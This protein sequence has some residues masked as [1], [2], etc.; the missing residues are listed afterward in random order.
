MRVW[1]LPILL[2][3]ILGVACAGPPE[4]A[5]EPDQKAVSIIQLIAD[6]KQLD[7]SNILVGGYLEIRDEYEHSL[8]LDENAQRTGMMGNSIAI[9]LGAFRPA[10]KKRAEELDR[11]Y[12]IL[13]G[14]FKA[15]PTAF[16]GGKLESVYSIIPAQP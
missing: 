2:S 13:G 9:D 1:K 16:S 11:T 7:G 6:P 4:L 3:L 8:F 12:V 5:N 14:R 10:L 15:G